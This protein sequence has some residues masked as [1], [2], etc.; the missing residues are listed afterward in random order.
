MAQ[1]CLLHK[2]AGRQINGTKQFATQGSGTPNQWHK[3]VRYTKQRDAK[4]MAQNSLLLKAAGRQ[5]NGT[6]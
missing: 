4:L 5:I 1:D 2:A 6:K 3:I